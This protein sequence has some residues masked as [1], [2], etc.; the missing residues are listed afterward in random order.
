VA[1]A[2]PVTGRPWT[3]FYDEGVPAALQYPEML[4]H[5]ILET[6]A[7]R[8]A[9]RA[10]LLF[11]GRQITF[12]SLDVLVARFAA[13]LQ[14]LG[15]RRGTPVSLHLPNSPQFVIAYYGI[16]KAGGIAVPH[17]PLYTE[18]EVAH[19]LAD[20]GV[21]VAVTLD[22]MFPQVAPAARRSGVR[23]LVVTAIQE[24]MPAHLRL[25]YPIKA[26]REGHWVQVPPQADVHAFSALLKGGPAQPVEGSPHDPALYQY[27]G[28][29][30]GIPKAAI[31]THRNLVSN[32]LQASAWNAATS[33]PGDRAMAV[34]P[35]FHIYGMTAVL[36]FAMWS[37]LCIVLIPRFDP[38]MVLKAAHRTRPAVFHGVPTMYTA[39][40]NRPDLG[41][42]DLRSIQTC[43]SGAMGLPQEVQRSWE[44]A[45]GG[46]LVEGYGLTEASPITHC[47]PVRGHRRP[48]SIGV[49]FPDTDARIA[50]PET[51]RELP[52]GDVGELAV[53]GP[54]VMRGYLNRPEETAA[55]L[56][57]GW[58][59]TGDMAR[60]DADGF[61]YIVDRKKEM[62]NVGGLKVYPREVEEVL[63]GHP[64]VREAAA[65]GV[66]DPMKG[67]V[68][69]AFVAL[70]D[71][72]AA[73]G[74]ELIAFCRERL[75]PYKTPRAL[76]VRD[77]LPKTL[78]G[79]ILRRALA[80]EDRRR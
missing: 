36:N 68:V 6:S 4:V 80:D 44:A 61:F 49:P 31:L 15:V 29:T 46:R 11:F 8:H 52:I 47:T 69:K 21:Q 32:A 53:Q 75:A 34:L 74:E 77:S 20:A 51:G 16:L 62:I 50:D 63:Y 17:N 2:V 39:L 43:I 55:T 33:H 13:G 28:G 65:I 1:T 24:Y 35:F 5:Q 57:D 78:I 3:K 76:E 59:F 30:T 37:G 66:P 42:Y 38:V 23:H 73:T 79:K 67:E 26:R 27:T 48:G 72:A 14:R 45:T 70:K 60:M 18:R 25:L 41:R 12:A 22:M 56:R 71:G 10:A 54:Q 9:D 58:L 40:L 7:R 19:Q 64:A